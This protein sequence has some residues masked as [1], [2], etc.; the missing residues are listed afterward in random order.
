M[1]AQIRE[2]IEERTALKRGRG[3]G[4]RAAREQ[5]R[6]RKRRGLH[7]RSSRDCAPHAPA[8]EHPTTVSRNATTKARKHEDHTKNL[9]V[10]K[11][12]FVRLRDFA[13]SW[14]RR[15]S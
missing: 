13:F 5:T 9:F 15:S 2:L 6:G 1:T 3:E 8:F 11:V 4:G 14:S 10:L 7:E 12:F